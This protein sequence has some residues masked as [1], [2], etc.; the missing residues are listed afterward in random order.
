MT[1]LAQYH[2]FGRTMFNVWTSPVTSND[3]TVTSD[4]G[5]RGHST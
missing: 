4:G 3:G 1:E 5:T 2:S